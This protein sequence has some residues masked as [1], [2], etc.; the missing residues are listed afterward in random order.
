MKGI[1]PGKQDGSYTLN[2]FAAT[3]T[4]KKIGDKAFVVTIK[5]KGEQGVGL[6]IKGVQ[7]TI[8]VVGAVGAATV[9]TIATAS[10]A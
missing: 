9:G 4:G 6:L 5:L 3:P 1:L 2:V 7:Q 10:S 8:T